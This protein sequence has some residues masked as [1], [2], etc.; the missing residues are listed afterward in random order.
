MVH[1]QDPEYI[2]PIDGHMTM[3]YT[4]IW[5]YGGIEHGAPSECYIYNDLCHDI[6]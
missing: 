1:P 5:S 3:R 2:I 6:L 4:H